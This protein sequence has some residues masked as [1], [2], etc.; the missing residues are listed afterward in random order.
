DFDPETDKVAYSELTELDRW[1]LMRLTRLIERVT[2]GYTDFDLHVFYHAVHNFCAVDMS[3]FYLDVIKDRI[4]ASL[5]K[6]KQRRAA[7]TVLWEAL[8]TLVR[9]IAPVLT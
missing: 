2:E 4:Y 8:N 1:A 3:A 7:Q 5:P 6:S 9:L